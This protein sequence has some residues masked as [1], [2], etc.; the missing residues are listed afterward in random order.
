LVVRK[1]ILSGN[2]SER[3]KDAELEEEEG[4]KRPQEMKQ[5]RS[6]TPLNVTHLK[7]L[8]IYHWLIGEPK[9]LSW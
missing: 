6:I 1:H 4:E 5:T 7:S 3:E 8:K 2:N 9:D